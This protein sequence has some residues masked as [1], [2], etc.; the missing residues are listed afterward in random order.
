MLYTAMPTDFI[1]QLKV[2]PKYNTAAYV[3]QMA[4]KFQRDIIA[5]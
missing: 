2:K 1:N 3:L 5:V 4:L